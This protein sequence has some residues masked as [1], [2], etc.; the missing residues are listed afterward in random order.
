MSKLTMAGH[1]FGGITSLEAAKALDEIKYCVSLD[2]WF[3]FIVDEIDDQKYLIPK[4][5]TIINTYGFHHKK[6]MI[7]DFDSMKVLMKV[8]EQNK[9]PGNSN[10][11]IK[12]SDHAQ[13]CD[14]SLLMGDSLEFYGMIPSYRKNLDI[15]HLSNRLM[16]K[17]L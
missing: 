3:T 7:M 9:K 10:I 1:S 17:F 6:T 2:P 12:N 13:Q 15:M 5:F 8:W 11:I 14:I 16:I 4:P